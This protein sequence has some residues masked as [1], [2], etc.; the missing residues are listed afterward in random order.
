M[1]AD[2]KQVMRILGHRDIDIR[3]DSDG[4]LQARWRHGDQLPADMAAF[5]QHYK[6]LIVTELAEAREQEVA[7]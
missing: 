6:A 5:I 1:S 2:P 7:A 4:Q 3:L